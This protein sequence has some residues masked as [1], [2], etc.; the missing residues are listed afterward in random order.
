M[1]V[2]KRCMIVKIGTSFLDFILK[3]F[4]YENRVV[5]VH[6]DQNVILVF[7]IVFSSWYYEVPIGVIL[8]NRTMI[9]NRASEKHVP[10]SLMTG[11]WWKR[12]QKAFK[13]TKNMICWI[14]KKLKR[15]NILSHVHITLYPKISGKLPPPF[16]FL[17]ISFRLA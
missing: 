4:Y 5:H 11:G 14:Q 13:I 10:F 8:G 1:K 3:P 15:W 7:V 9:S 6:Y 2:F 16:K 12:R 17:I